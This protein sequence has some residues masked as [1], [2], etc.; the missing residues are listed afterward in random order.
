MVRILFP[1][2]MALMAFFGPWEQTSKGPV[3]G[4][5]LADNTIGCFIDLNPSITGECAPAGEIA[6]QLVSYTVVGGGFA[7]VLGIFGLLPIVSRITSLATLVAGGVGLAA[8]LATVALAVNGA[9]L[10]LV[11]WGAWG[12]LALGMFTVFAGLSG[13]RDGNDY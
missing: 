7:A 1:L 12:T 10:S 9:G 13:F 8:A 5:D 2:F 6:E 4:F 3:H 11:G